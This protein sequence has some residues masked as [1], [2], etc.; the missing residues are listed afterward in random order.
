M[1]GESDRDEQGRLSELPDHEIDPQTSVGA[2]VTAAGGTATDM[3]GTAADT[4]GTGT[5]TGRPRWGDDEATGNDGD[6]G[7]ETVQAAG[8]AIPSLGGGT[9]GAVVGGDYTDDADEVIGTEDRDR[10]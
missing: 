7:G 4:G 9:M 5:D 2:G 8:A 3:G 10:G 6:A 1:A